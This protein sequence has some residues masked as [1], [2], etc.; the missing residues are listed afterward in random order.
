MKK[1]WAD[2]KVEYGRG[3]FF[4]ATFMKPSRLKICCLEIYTFILLTTQYVAFLLN[5][6]SSSYTWIGVH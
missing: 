5:L 4:L 1:N 2:V 6:L 3:R